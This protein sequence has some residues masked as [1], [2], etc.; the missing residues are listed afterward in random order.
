MKIKVITAL[1]CLFGVCTQAQNTTAL[2]ELI[3]RRVPFLKN[4]VVFTAIPNT[5]RDTASYYTG[6]QKL[7]I[8]SSNTLSAAYAL[9]EYLR[10][11]CGISFSHTG[12]QITE[13]AS[14][15]EVKKAVPV[16]AAFRYRY[17]LNYCTY[18]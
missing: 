12:D 8:Q 14:L 16:A 15:P 1:A 4:K 17:A 10:T 11:Y 9:N 6:N 7:Y 2:Q 13:P 5:N 3:Q 18:N